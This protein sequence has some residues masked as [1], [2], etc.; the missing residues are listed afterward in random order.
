MYELVNEKKLNEH[1]NING[2]LLKLAEEDNIQT[3]IFNNR[4]DRGYDLEGFSSGAVCYLLYSIIWNHY[5]SFAK[6]CLLLLLA[7]A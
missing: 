3:T 7:K 1:K 6:L 2:A 4:K 5:R